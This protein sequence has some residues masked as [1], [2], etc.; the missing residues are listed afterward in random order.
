MV[1]SFC[2]KPQINN[3][4]KVQDRNVCLY[5][6]YILNT[7]C[8]LSIFHFSNIII[9]LM[10]LT[11]PTLIVPEIMLYSHFSETVIEVHHTSN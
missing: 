5:I 9:L 10:K 1:L 7:L 6:L 3:V 8:N 4:P 2:T 11:N